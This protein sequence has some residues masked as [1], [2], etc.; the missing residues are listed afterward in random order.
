MPLDS[1]QTE[2]SFSPNLTY[3]LRL[4]L[5]QVPRPSD[6]AIFVSTTATTTTTRPI[7]LPLAY[8]RGVM[9]CLLIRVAKMTTIICYSWQV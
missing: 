8:A 2:A 7:T 5:A 4:Q 6:L 1:E 9:M 3:S